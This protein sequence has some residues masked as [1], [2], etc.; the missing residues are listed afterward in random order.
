MFYDYTLVINTDK[1][2]LQVQL[3][4]LASQNDAQIE[5]HPI[6]KEDFNS[7]SPFVAEINRTG[8]EIKS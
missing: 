5:P 8:I 7:N 2:D 4:I 1:F 3:I 6:F